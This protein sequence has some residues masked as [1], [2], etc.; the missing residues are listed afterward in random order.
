ML[1]IDLRNQQG[2]HSI[3]EV[4]FE[5]LEALLSRGCYR[6]S[7]QRVRWPQYKPAN[8]VSIHRSDCSILSLG[9]KTTL[10]QTLK[11]AEEI[12]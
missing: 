4:V 1:E 8:F 10:P 12:G 7:E 2:I 5:G 3:P 9:S 6:L 11:F